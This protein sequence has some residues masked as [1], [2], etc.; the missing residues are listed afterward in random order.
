MSDMTG[1]RLCITTWLLLL[2]TII[3]SVSF[4]SVEANEA[5][6]ARMLRDQVQQ[7]G[8]DLPAISHANNA[9]SVD[10]MNATIHAAI[11]P[12]QKGTDLNHAA[13]K[14]SHEASGSDHKASDSEHEAS[15]SD[16]EAEKPAHEAPTFMM[17][18]GPAIA[19]VIAVALI[20]GIIAFKNRK[21]K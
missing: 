15:G 1:C 21:S 13:T 7:D 2:A 6:P 11:E 5:V 19:G 20:G 12:G 18:M 9:G 4:S 14:P 10:D 8:A 17:F 16:H 3:C